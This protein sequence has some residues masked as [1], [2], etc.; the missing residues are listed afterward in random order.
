[1]IRLT[2]RSLIQAG[3]AASAAPFIN[4]DGNAQSAL[5][6]A[7]FGYTALGKTATFIRNGA[8]LFARWMPVSLQADKPAQRSNVELWSGK[9]AKLTEPVLVDLLSGQIYQLDNATFSNGWWKIE[10]VPLSD[11]PLVITDKSVV[12]V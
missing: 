12:Q 5:P 11:S 10:N 7:A 9:A 2:R 3:L 8:P 1:M 4:I 6:A